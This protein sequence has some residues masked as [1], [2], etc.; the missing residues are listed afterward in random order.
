[1]N[2]AALDLLWDL[3]CAGLTPYVRPDGT[4][5]L[6]RRHA[7]AALTPDLK[8][9]LDALREPVT[10]LARARVVMPEPESAPREE[11]P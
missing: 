6:Y 10:E 4:P 9:R 1:M 3:A 11:L 7:G 5:A 2:A 8:G